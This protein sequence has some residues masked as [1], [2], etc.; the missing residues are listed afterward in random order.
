MLV[1]SLFDM[2]FDLSANFTVCPSRPPCGSGGQ[3]VLLDALRDHTAIQVYIRLLRRLL[4]GG[5][6]LKDLC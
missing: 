1:F 5:L 6:D 2:D 4:R 3:A